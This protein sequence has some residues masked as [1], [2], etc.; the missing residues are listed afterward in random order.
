MLH[1]KTSEHWCRKTSL[2]AGGQQYVFER[3]RD[4]AAV[5][6]GRE[7]DGY[8]SEW[9]D[10]TQGTGK[11]RKREGEKKKSTP[12]T[13]KNYLPRYLPSLLIA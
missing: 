11:V 10:F 5:E 2:D 13:D 3:T 7:I 6:R 1:K 12:V 9:K 8:K 4:N